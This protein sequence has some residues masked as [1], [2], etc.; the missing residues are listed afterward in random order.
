M[1]INQVI[2]TG[3]I[4]KDFELRRGGQNNTAYG[5]FTIANNAFKNNQ[6]KTNFIDCKVVGHNAEYVAK[7]LKKGSFVIVSGSLE[8]RTY[9]DKNGNNVKV[10]EISVKEIKADVKS[11]DT[12]PVNQPE[13]AI[14]A[15][16]A[17]AQE[18][19]SDEDLPF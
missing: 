3:R 16:Q 6:E 17:P 19:I 13:R 12:K 14:K 18:E 10:V 1:D 15:N 11:S 8:T 4:T 2:L 7:Y 9:Q 5:T